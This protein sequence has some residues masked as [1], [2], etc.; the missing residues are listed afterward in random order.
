MKC[1][2][3]ALG[4]MIVLVLVGVFSVNAMAEQGNADSITLSIDRTPM[5]QTIF[6]PGRLR[7]GPATVTV[8]GFM[9]RDYTGLPIEDFVMKTCSGRTMIPI[10]TVMEIRLS[11]WSFRRTNDIYLIENVVEVEIDLTDGTT[12]TGLMNADFGTIEGKTEL[13]DFFLGDP[14]YVRHLVF[15]R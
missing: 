6:H 1:T 12:R 5:G 9:I 15:N 3:T 4:L 8:R 7:T 11:R 10:E 2:K 13:G 14:L